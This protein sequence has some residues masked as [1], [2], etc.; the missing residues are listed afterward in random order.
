LVR[1]QGENLPDTVTLVDASGFFDVDYYLQQWPAL[2]V[3][4]CDPI[5]HYL[6]DGWRQK[7]DPGPNFSTSSYLATN[8]DVRAAGIN[9]LVHYLRS[10]K[11]EGRRIFP[12]R[13]RHGRRRPIAPSWEQWDALIKARRS[14]KAAPLVDVIVP[15]YRG[16]DET[17]RCLFSVL[18]TKQETPYQLVVVDDSSPEIELREQLD[19]LVA[20]RLIDLHR[21]GENVGFVRACNLGLALHL[22]RDVILLNADTEVFGDWLDR[23]HAAALRQRRTG[24]VTPFSNNAEICSYPHFVQDNWLALEVSDEVIDQMA[25]RA[26]ADAEVEIPTG[27]GFCMYIRRA[28][29]DEIGQFDVGSFGMGYGEENDF[30]RRAAA[31]GWRNILAPN[32]FVRHYGA[33]SFGEKKAA[34]VQAALDIL[35]RLHP[36][37]L[38]IVEHFIRADPVRPF[39]E[40][41]DV[42]RLARRAGTGAVL[43]VTHT[44]G[45]G[46]ERHVQ[47]MTEILEAEGVPVFYC[48][49]HARYPW[50]IQI[51]DLGTWE[52]PNLSLFDPVR[53]L[54]Q[55]AEVL[56]RIGVFHVH[57]HHF[58]GFPECAP[59]F[60]RAACDAAGL[61][62]DVTIHDYMAVCPRINMID[63]SGLYCGEPDLRTCETCIEKSG[64][65]FGKPSVWEWRERYARLLLSARR[66]FVPHDDVARRMRRFLPRVDFVV[67]PHFESTP[68]PASMAKTVGSPSSHYATARPE[69]G[70]PRRVAVL[71]AI[72][73]HKGAALLADTARAAMDRGL[74]LE[75]VV[76]GYTD[77][78]AELRAIGNVVISGR[79]KEGEAVQQLTAAG[80]DVAWFPAV[81]P[82]TY[83][84]TLS[85]A[86]QARVFPAAFNLGAI[87]SRLRVLGWGE[88]MALESMLDPNAI[89]ERLAEMPIVPP[90]DDGVHLLASKSYADPLASYYGLC[91]ARRS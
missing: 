28:C 68:S 65:P 57:I 77:R 50:L 35:E 56:R 54:N 62:Y 52:T 24:T 76:V 72:G 67:R 74:P 66:V 88:L 41:L 27:V 25:A 10:G 43:F 4:N 36:S 33:A 38:R 39:R 63:R 82:E 69:P 90:P 12:S 16:L 34:R 58:A 89:A 31:V 85:A 11:N 60:F 70:Q 71:G 15:V 6:G 22:E 53:D 3:E 64:S 40:A 81:W 49:A 8:D 21:T 75:F 80:A 20:Q 9:P 91:D 45:G 14:S 42:A 61:S 78:D 17:M 23:L 37:Y 83:S 44:W 13:L 26:N 32:V 1:A 84:Y 73:Q 5:V 29:L 7:A 55:F 59:D 47:D 79:F 30:C 87:A 48:R 51:E 46:T 18:S 2:L 86:L 19:R